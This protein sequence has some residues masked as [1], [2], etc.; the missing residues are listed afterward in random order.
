MLTPPMTAV[1]IVFTNTHH[2]LR[3]WSLKL[4]LYFLKDS[5]FEFAYMAVYK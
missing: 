2:I 4:A 3:A 5:V 1:I